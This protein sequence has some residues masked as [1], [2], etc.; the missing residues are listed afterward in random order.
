MQ[1]SIARIEKLILSKKP[2]QHVVI[3]ASKVNLLARDEKLRAIINESP[4]VNADGQSIIWAARFLGHDI[5]E[6][7]TGIDLFQALIQH[8]EKKG[9]RP[10]YFGATEEVVQQVVKK[11]REMYPMLDIAG[12]RNGYFKD[13]ESFQIAEEI[14]A[15]QADLLFVAFSSPKKEFWIDAHKD[16]MQVPFVMGVGGSFDI[17]AGKT[18]RAPKWIQKIGME[19]FYRFLQEPVRMFER[20]VVGN[21]H[22]VKLV[23]REKRKQ[24]WS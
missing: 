2:I 8:A 17:V 21:F 15:S 5:P 10:Y 11:H 24:K 22:F 13:W 12:Y 14:K 6:R 3:N 4:I 1:E 23:L 9:L 20:Y 7:V 18:K 16:I 19:W